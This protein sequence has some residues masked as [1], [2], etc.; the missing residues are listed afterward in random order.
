MN[1]NKN[2]NRHPKRRMS[3]ECPRC[4]NVFILS[5]N[6]N[7]HKRTVTTWHHPYN[8]KISNIIIEC[9]DC[10][11]EVSLGNDYSTHNE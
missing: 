3:V 10:R 2:Y 6:L 4:Q 1:K 8:G 9:P 5:W 11:Y 7:S